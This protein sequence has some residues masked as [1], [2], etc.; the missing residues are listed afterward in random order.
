MY[1]VLPILLIGLASPLLAQEPGLG[2]VGEGTQTQSVELLKDSVSVSIESSGALSLGRGNDSVGGSLGV[3]VND[4]TIV[5]IGR[6]STSAAP[7]S[8]GAGVTGAT[9]VA[10]AN[11]T[12]GAA[13]STGAS[14]QQ[15]AVQ[16]QGS[17]TGAAGSLTLACSETEGG[18]EKLIGALTSGQEVWMRPTTCTTPRD[19]IADLASQYPQLEQAV[20]GAGRSFEDVVAITISDDFVVLD[21]LSAD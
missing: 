7:G 16:G 11:G 14:G 10:T 9:G 8:A 19:D 3:S 4:V 13:P 12:A 18:R 21:M 1:R 6:E 20:A 15:V 17:G 5:S 2:I